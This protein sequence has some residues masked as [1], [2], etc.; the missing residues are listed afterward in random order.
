M[1]MRQDKNGDVALA[2]PGKPRWISRDP[3]QMRKLMV[4]IQEL[5]IG[6]VPVKNDM[7]DQVRA[8]SKRG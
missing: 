2:P 7:I 8:G 3:D 5:G 1:S 4:R 6:Y